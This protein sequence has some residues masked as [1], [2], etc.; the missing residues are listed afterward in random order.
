MTAR[1]YG[2]RPDVPDHRD[3][4]HRP[5]YDAAALPAHVDLSPQMPEPY[6]QGSLGSCTAHAIGGAIAYERGLP[7]GANGLDIDW[8]RPS[9]LFIYYC[10]RALEGTTSQDAGAYIRDGAKVTAQQG[11]PPALTWP[12]KPELFAHRPHKRAYREALNTRVTS[13]MRVAQFAS[14]LR[15]VL[16]AGDTIVFGFSVYESFESNEVARTGIVPMPK[17]HESMLG[18]H[19]VLLVGYDNMTKLFKVRNS[20]GSDWG[21]GGYFWMPYDYVCDPDLADDFWTLRT[22]TQETT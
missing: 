12:Y 13:Y 5:T 11:I 20:W 19:A 10:E 18:G 3:R 6:D 22:I 8:F 15:A 17:P 9:F 2:W 4:V 7:R 14:D 16:A 21:D 1:T